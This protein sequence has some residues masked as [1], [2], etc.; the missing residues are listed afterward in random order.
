VSFLDADALR[1]SD[2][3]I[4]I[5]LW[6]EGSLVLSGLG[7]RF[8]SFSRELFRARNHARVAGLLAHGVTRPDV[9]E[10][11]V[12]TGAGA[13]PAGLE[14]YDTHLTVIPDGG[15]PWQIP[16]GAMTG[17]SLEET[18]PAV[19]ISAGGVR[20]VVGM[21][22]K[23]LGVFHRAVAERRNASSRTLEGL[24]GSTVFRDGLGVTADSVPG[25][26]QIL[27]RST[28]PERSGNART[29]LDAATAPARLGFVQLLDPDGDGLVA[30]E[31]LPEPWAS[32]LLVP[33]GAR[34]A[35]EVLA[36]P[37]AATY[38]FDAP[39]DV[40]NRDLQ[41]LHFRRAPL[42]LTDAQAEITPANP[43]RL[44]LRRLEALKRLRT[45]TVA[46]VLHTDGWQEALGKALR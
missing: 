37:R 33:A 15:D 27:E 6:P 10:G 45:A 42:A 24:T 30:R 4:E 26:E 14:V 12:S 41:A 31:P 39:V 7:R 18:P 5:D 3:R 38:V 2:H 23:R 25:F 44:A 22:G 40:V 43:H 1:I 11:R 16:L 9:F 46:R 28:A 13:G 20:T 21:L 34:T 29:L 17:L 8:D 36:G 32:F 19:A 35:L